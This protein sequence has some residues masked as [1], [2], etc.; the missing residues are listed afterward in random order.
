M[1]VDLD[2]GAGQDREAGNEHDA[3]PVGILE[4]GRVGVPVRV[5][6]RHRI[7]VQPRGDGAYGGVVAEV[8]HEQR[9][10]VRFGRGVPPAG[11]ELEVR[12][13]A[14][15]REE[16]AVVAV[17]V[18]EAADLGQADPVAVKPHKLVQPFGCGG[19]CAPSWL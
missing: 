6:G 18:V 16:H 17:V 1:P 14:G 2:R 8:E 19:Q 4:R 11:R 5:R 15:K 7:G 9:L 3:E 12:A 13:G 10:R